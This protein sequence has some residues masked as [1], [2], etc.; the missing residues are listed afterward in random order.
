VAGTKHDNGKPLL[1]LFPP[2]AEL[3]AGKA[4]TH[5]KTEYG[6]FNYLGGLDAIRALSAVRRHINAFLRGEDVDAESGAHHLGCAIAGLAMTIENLVVH[7][8][9]HDDRYD[10]KGK[11]NAAV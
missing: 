9:K 11:K 1:A 6:Q 3:E 2:Y 7:G 4:F 5:G 8:D 10:Y